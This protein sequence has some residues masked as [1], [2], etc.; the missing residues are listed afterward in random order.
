MAWQPHSIT[1]SAV[2]GKIGGTCRP[3]AR[4][5]PLGAPS[6]AAL[7]RRASRPIYRRRSSPRPR[8]RRMSSTSW[9]R[10]A[11]RWRGRSLRAALVALDAE[12]A[13]L[14]DQVA[15]DDRAVA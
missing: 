15:E 4:S 5:D 8:C 10:Y 12:R 1:S 2:A 13:E 14:A 9:T 11:D 7:D 3:S 6:L